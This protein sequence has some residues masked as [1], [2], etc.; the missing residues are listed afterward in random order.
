MRLIT[1]IVTAVLAIVAALFAVSNR[2]IV[3][4]ALWPLPLAIALPLYLMVFL[5]FL[6]GFVIGGVAAWFGAGASRSRARRAERRVTELERELQ[7]ARQR[8]KA[9]EDRP[10]RTNLPAGREASRGA[11]P[12]AAVAS[13]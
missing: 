8:L 13:R 9:S 10:G 5:P 11:V 12:T 3:E 6:I 1:L 7:D 4:L 2:E